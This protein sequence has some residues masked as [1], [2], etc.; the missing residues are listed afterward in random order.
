MASVN[1][2]E[3]EQ[4]SHNVSEKIIDSI[5]AKSSKP[6]I[7]VEFF[8]PKTETGPWQGILVPFRW[9]CAGW[10]HNTDDLGLDDHHRGYNAVH[11]HE[12]TQTSPAGLRRLHVGSRFDNCI[13]LSYRRQNL[14]LVRKL[15]E[16]YLCSGGSTSDLTLDLCRRAKAE[17]DLNPNMHLTCTNMEL[18]KVEAALEGCKSSGN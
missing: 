11:R 4:E 15:T 2:I 5:L 8:P 13:C 6:W 9:D 7:S 3:E 10:L 14:H 16:I 18:E 1:I 12:G 17:L